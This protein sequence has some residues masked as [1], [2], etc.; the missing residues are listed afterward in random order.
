MYKHCKYYAQYYPEDKYVICLILMVYL[1][2]FGCGV[3]PFILCYLHNHWIT[4]SHDLGEDNQLMQ[5]LVHLMNC[6]DF[7]F[8]VTRREQ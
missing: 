1:D 4:V 8:Q 2:C 7:F 3:F 6:I 5:S